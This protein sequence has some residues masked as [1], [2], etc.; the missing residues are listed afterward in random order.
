MR[1]TPFG[2][3]VEASAEHLDDLRKEPGKRA[4]LFSMDVGLEQGVGRVTKLPQAVTHGEGEEAGGFLEGPLG[5]RP[6]EAVVE[7]EEE[8]ALAV[9]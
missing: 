9:G 2:E 4:V 1:A 3:L 7:A 6:D 5:D 8:E